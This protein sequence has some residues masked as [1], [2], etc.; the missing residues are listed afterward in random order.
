MIA[1]VMP[2]AQA[3]K[4]ASLASSKRLLVVGLDMSCPRK[5]KVWIIFVES[6]TTDDC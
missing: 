2:P 1:R 6:D 4:I 5:V 3:A